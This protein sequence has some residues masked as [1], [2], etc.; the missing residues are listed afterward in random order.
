MKIELN[1]KKSLGKKIVLR[2]DTEPVLNGRRD[3]AGPGDQ[4]ELE[5]L[6][7]PSVIS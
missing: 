6:I 2:K 7:S 3:L 5:A 1:W 4:L